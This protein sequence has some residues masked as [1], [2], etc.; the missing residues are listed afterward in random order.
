MDILEKIE[1][2]GLMVRM[3]SEILIN[4]NFSIF[5]AFF[6]LLNRLN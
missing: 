2:F 3:V 4:L 1:V 5:L 6:D